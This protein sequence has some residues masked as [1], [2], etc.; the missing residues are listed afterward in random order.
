MFTDE[1]NVKYTQKS[2]TVM[3]QGKPITVTEFSPILTADQREKKK[4]N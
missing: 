1:Q 4:R 3:F 2:S